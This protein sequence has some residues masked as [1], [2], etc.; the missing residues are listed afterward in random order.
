MIS[1]IGEPFYTE[2]KFHRR[3]PLGVLFLHKHTIIPRIVPGVGAAL[4]FL[5][6]ILN[7]LSHITHFKNYFLSAYVIGFVVTW[8]SDLL[9]V[10]KT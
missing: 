3:H 1:F 7:L 2:N 6:M 8:D 9:S 4:F 5:S 10:N